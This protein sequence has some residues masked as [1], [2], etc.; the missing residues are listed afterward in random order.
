M[1]RD[2][3][4][5]IIGLKIS[6]EIEKAEREL[7]KII[8]SIERKKSK[9][10]ILVNQLIAKAEEKK[11]LIHALKN[12]SESIKQ[13]AKESEYETKVDCLLIQ[14]RMNFDCIFTILFFKFID[15]LK[16]SDNFRSL[17]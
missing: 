1:F 10:R 6:E 16:F 3:N 5:N 4:L 7:A 17:N 9:D 15:S 12:K 14:N 8:D 2:T 13:E 11:I